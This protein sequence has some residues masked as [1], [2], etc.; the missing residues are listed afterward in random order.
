MVKRQ[1]TYNM[2]TKTGEQEPVRHRW[3][4]MVINEP[5]EIE[6]IIERIYE[7]LRPIDELKNN[8][9]GLL[10]N[11]NGLYYK[12][13]SFSTDKSTIPYPN[14]IY[15]SKNFRKDRNLMERNDVGLDRY[16]NSI[17]KTEEIKNTKKDINYFITKACH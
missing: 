5:R 12:F 9:E 4:F 15:D 6:R 1:I 8:Y 10:P 16:L 7:Q 2:R 3:T 17:I 14:K 11:S 13:F